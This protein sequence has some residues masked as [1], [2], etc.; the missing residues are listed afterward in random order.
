MARLSATAELVDIYELRP[1]DVLVRLRTGFAELPSSY[2]VPLVN[3]SAKL[4]A[5]NAAVSLISGKWK[6]HESIKIEN[7]L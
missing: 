7:A 3:I 2:V 6:L 5:Q 4:S 1:T